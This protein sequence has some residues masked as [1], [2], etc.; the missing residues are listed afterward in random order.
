M[1]EWCVP[2][3]HTHKVLGL[4]LNLTVAI[5]KFFMVLSKYFGKIMEQYLH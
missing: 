3:P 1:V 4:I 2:L 5:L